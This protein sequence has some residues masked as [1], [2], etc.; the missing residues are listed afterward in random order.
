MTCLERRD[1]RTGSQT[2]KEVRLGITLGMHEA[3]SGAI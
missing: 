2:G 1:L 3:R